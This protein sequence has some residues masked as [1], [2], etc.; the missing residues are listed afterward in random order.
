VVKGFVSAVVLATA[1]SSVVCR[2]ALRS[3]RAG[4]AAVAV[5]TLTLISSP[6]NADDF[7]GLGFLPAT[8]ISTANGI[9]A[10]GTVVVGYSGLQAYRWTESGGMV[11]LGFLPG[12]T[13]S[14]A[15]GVN[16]DGSVVVGYSEFHG[17]SFGRR[18]F[19][20]TQGG[21]MVSLGT[22]FGSCSA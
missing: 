22:L 11:G 20:W 21:G 14:N 9:S 13:F 16:A 5:A 17:S 1:V 12:Q 10:D 3:R 2:T 18:A 6:S 4:R 8:S 7:S 15:I 19:R